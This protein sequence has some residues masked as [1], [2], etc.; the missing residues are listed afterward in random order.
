[1]SPPGQ[2]SISQATLRILRHGLD[3]ERDSLTE[4]DLFGSLK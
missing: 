2:I 1:M 3:K 4:E